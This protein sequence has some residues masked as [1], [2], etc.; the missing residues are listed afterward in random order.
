MAYLGEDSQVPRM[1]RDD[2][3][4]A[5]QILRM[6]RD[7]Y[8]NAGQIPRMGRDEIASRAEELLDE[9]WDG[10]LPIDV[11]AICDYLG[12]AIV[13]VRGLKKEFEVE[14]YTAV[15]FK[16]I[17]VDWSSYESGDARYR[18]SVAHELG[19]FALHREYFPSR[20]EDF[21]E[22][23]GMASNLGYV[24]FQANYFAGSLLA[25]EVDLI[26]A[27]NSEFGG[28][29]ARNCW[30]TSREEFRSVLNRVQKF[31]GV[32]R[33]VLARRMRDLMPG[34]EMFEEVAMGLRR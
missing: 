12:I 16:T 2:Y 20:V 10:R 31:F 22:W 28:S 25:P 33:Q 6:G 23:R 9:C 1:G 7:D 15:D 14:A 32:S 17:Y 11:E 19:H 26:F 3:C 4:N 34:A 30:E 29:F 5:G 24:E 13:P 8:C 21:D 18:F 27:L